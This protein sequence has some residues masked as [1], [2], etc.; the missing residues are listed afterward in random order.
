MSWTLKTVF[1]LGRVSNLPT[2]WTNTLA[3]V[4]L[5]GASPADWRILVLLL[6]M[7]LAYTGGMFLNDAF[8][9]AIDARE[10]SERPIPSGKVSAFSVSVYGYLMLV[11]SVILVALCAYSNEGGAWKA[12]L[13]AIALACAIILYNAWHKANPL[14][15]L[16]MGLCRMLVYITAAY[17]VTSTPTSMVFIGALV[18][19]S[20]LIGLTFTAKQENL[21]RVKNLW[22][23]LFLAAP[24]VFAVNILPTQPNVLWPLLLFTLWLVVALRFILRRQTG[25]IPRAVVSMI[26]GISLIDAMFI[27]SSSNLI[28]ASIAV[29]GFLATLVLQ[30][31]V[32]GT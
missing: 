15:P 10:R 6:S 27:A 26:A 13:S 7:T 21:G 25:D 5:A 1:D 23:L 29:V 31:W 20:Y 11:I 22:P 24:M 16:I 3:G 19:L 9:A 12:I 30:K 18:L 32:S 4:I 14:S 8:D 2:V 17:T 28:W